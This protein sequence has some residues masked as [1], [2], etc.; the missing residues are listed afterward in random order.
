MRTLF[1]K[2][3]VKVGYLV[4][5]LLLL[6]SQSHAATY[7]FHNDQLGT[8][9]VVTDSQ[10]QVAWEGEYDPFGRV[11]ETVSVVEQN[12]RFPGQYFDEESGLHYNYYRTY[13]PT[14]GRY[15]ESDPIGLIAGLNTYSYVKNSPIIDVDP[16][17]LIGKN[18]KGHFRP[19]KCRR[20]AM[21]RCVKQCENRGG[22]KSCAETI[23]SRPTIRNGVPTNEIYFV[24]GS[25]NCVCNED[26]ND[27]EDNSEPGGTP[28]IFPP[29]PKPGGG[30]C[31]SPMECTP[32]SPIQLASCVI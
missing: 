9:Q 26:D 19:V 27:P 20:E 1:A 3:L 25:M 18:P 2:K 29:I 14:V 13:D 5:S 8:P 28:F 15:V 31:R 22:V 4:T 30:G 12:I 10:Q 21:G 23:G 17:G 7:F 24:P 32:T 11:N 6:T 16:L